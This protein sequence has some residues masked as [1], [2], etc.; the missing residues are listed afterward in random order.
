MIPGPDPYFDPLEY[1]LEV[2]QRFTVFS[3]R[4]CK[5]LQIQDFFNRILQHF[6]PPG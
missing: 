4:T 3:D 6:H 1:P 5:A 2:L